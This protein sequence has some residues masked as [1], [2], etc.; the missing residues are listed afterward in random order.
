MAAPLFVQVPEVLYGAG[1]RADRFVDAF[2]H[3]LD[4][5]IKARSFTGDHLQNLYAGEPLRSI[6]LVLPANVID[7]IADIKAGHGAA[8]RWIVT[9]ALHVARTDPL[10]PGYS[11]VAA[12]NAARR[13][14]DLKAA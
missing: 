3:G 8:N 10:S 6:R 9:A 12:A 1:P 4:I 11:A 13:E 5:A 2:V 7:K 14:A